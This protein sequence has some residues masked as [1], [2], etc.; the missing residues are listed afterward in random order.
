ME[1]WHK[2]L[3]KVHLGHERNV[4]ADYLIYLLHNIVNTDFRVT[5]LKIKTGLL[6]VELSTYDKT[7]KAKAM[8]LE[9]SLAKDMVTEQMNE[10]KVCCV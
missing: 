2:T 4:R 9:H 6:S 5:Y 8:R 7:R 10:S 1:S 3:K